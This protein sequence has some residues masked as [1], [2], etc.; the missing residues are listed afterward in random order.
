MGMRTR[1]LAGCFAMG[2]TALLLTGTAAQAAPLSGAH[3]SASVSAVGLSE[4]ADGGPGDSTWTPSPTWTPKPPSTHTSKPKPTPT[5]TPTPTQTPAV[6]VVTTP[7][8]APSVTA[9][10]S[11]GANTGGGGS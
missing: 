10:P 2:A 8:P 7:S 5:P 11:G 6:T 3:V 4:H 1:V 9:V